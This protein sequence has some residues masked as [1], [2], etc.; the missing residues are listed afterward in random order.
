MQEV[1]AQNFCTFELG[2]QERT[3][4]PIWI[5]VGFQQREWHDSQKFNNGTFN[6]PSVTS[7]QCIIGTEIYP[8]SAILLNYDDDD[9]FS[10]GYGRIEEDFE[11][12]KIDDI[13]QPYISENDFRSPNNDND[14]SYKIYV[15]DVRYQR[16]LLSAQPFKVK[17]HFF[18]NVPAGIYGYAFVL[19]NNL[20][21]MSSDEQR[22]FDFF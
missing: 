12:L 21:S 6:R 13:F 7:A 5:F 19:T 10:Q 2:T 20:V 17:F 18:E 9:D 1:K 16:N 22:H 4:V 3:K 15:F 11:A 14:I 8:D